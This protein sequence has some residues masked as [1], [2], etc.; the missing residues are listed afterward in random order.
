MWETAQQLMAAWDTWSSGRSLAHQRV[1]QVE[2]AF[3]QAV[4]DQGIPVTPRQW[5]LFFNLLIWRETGEAAPLLR[6][7]MAGPKKL[8]LSLSNT[9]FLMQPRPLGPAQMAIRSQ[10]II[11]NHLS[12]VFW[13]QH[14]RHFE[15][16]SLKDMRR[17]EDA[18]AIQWLFRGASWKCPPVR[19]EVPLL[20]ACHAHLRVSLPA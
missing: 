20:D 4:T 10:A 14:P 1:R 2:N 12:W 5:N 11:N 3:R 18:P 7:L 17:W 19:G 16:A 15:L 6:T 8:K 9:H 13:Q